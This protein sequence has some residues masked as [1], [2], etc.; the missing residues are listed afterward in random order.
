[1]CACVL[2]LLVALRIPSLEPTPEAAQASQPPTQSTNSL[3]AEEQ[4]VRDLIA[5]AYP[6]LKGADIRLREFRS[7][8]DYFRTSFS[9]VRFFFG[10]RMRYFVLVNPEWTARGAPIEGV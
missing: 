7:G 3:T 6:N 2:A 8:S 1:M 9:L 5:L 10:T 4:I